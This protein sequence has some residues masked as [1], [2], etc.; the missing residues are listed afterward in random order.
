MKKRIL[1]VFL[2][3]C[4]VLTLF[5]M[6]AF[7]VSFDDTQGHW[8]KASIDRWAGYGVL[9]GDKGHFNPNG[10]MTRAQFAQ[11][12][13]NMLG[14]TEKA[15]NTFPDVKGDAWYAEAILKL[16]AAGVILGDN[17]GNANP[18]KPITR[19]EAAVMLCRAFHIDTSA[20]Q[21]IPFAD[22]GKVQSWARG[23]VAALA[24]K[25][26][27]NGVG[28][29]NF[30]PQNNINRAAVAQMADNMIS[31]YVTG[32]ETVT[33]KVDGLVVVAGNANVTFQN[34]EVAENI[35]VAPKGK[36]ATVALSG[37]TKASDVVL[38]GE[39]SKVTVGQTAS[40]DTV[41][42]AAPRTAAEVAGKANTVSTEKEAQ[43]AEVTV[44]QKGTVANVEVAGANNKVSVSGTVKKVDVES[45]G[46]NASVTTAEGAKVEAVTTN[47]SKTTV[48]GASN[49]VGTVT[50]GS[51]ATGAKVTTGGAKV[52]NKSPDKVVTGDGKEIAA[53]KTD[54]AV[55]DT[56]GGGSSSGGGG[57]GTVTPSYKYTV[58]ATV[59]DGKGGTVTASKTQTNE[60]EEITLTITPEK[61]WKIESVQ[62][63]APG[64]TDATPITDN[65]GYKFSINEAKE[66][67][68]TVEVT[69]VQPLTTFDAAIATSQEE[70]HAFFHKHFQVT[71]EQID[72][73][74]GDPAG[75]PWLLIAAKPSKDEYKISSSNLSFTINGQVATASWQGN[76]KSGTFTGCSLFVNS[77][78]Q[79]NTDVLACGDRKTGDIVATATVGGVTYTSAPVTFYV[80]GTTADSIIEMKFDANYTGAP[81]ATV[82]KTT[83]NQEEVAP[84]LKRAGYDLEG[85]YEEKGCTTKVTDFKVTDATIK[86]VTYYAKWTATE[87]SLTYNANGGTGSVERGE[88]TVEDTGLTAAA[89]TGLTKAGHTFKGWAFDKNATT[90]DY[91][92]GAAMRA[93]DLIAKANEKT[94]TLYAVWEA[95]TY[96]VT[97]QD[98]DK[99]I[100]EATA[101]YNE[102]VTL[103]EEIPSAEGKGFVGWYVA[104]TLFTDET[105]ITADTTVIAKWTEGS[106]PATGG[107]SASVTGV[108]GKLG[109]TAATNEDRTLTITIPADVKEKY[110]KLTDAEKAALNHED[111]L[112]IRVNS[113]VPDN[114][115][116][117]CFFTGST[118]NGLT[119]RAKCEM[120]KEALNAKGID[121]TEEGGKIKT[122]G[123]WFG[124]A[125]VNN[126]SGDNFQLITPA[127]NWQVIYRW[128]AA[129]GTMSYTTFKVAF[130]HAPAEA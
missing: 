84:E 102:T 45:T 7:A 39:G 77:A 56:S 91:A 103:P 65:G 113:N 32:N 118:D 43:N 11:M 55:P 73:A 95:A 126:E 111:R 107:V 70:V 42:M 44:S 85:W 117:K 130:V 104:N 49:T 129:D 48:S 98:G 58:K 99:V 88:V 64:D 92:A 10:Q 35:L 87:Y 89:S 119:W 19:Q 54:T 81:A 14:Y 60:A 125:T 78:A 34:A 21:N 29:N 74:Y 17:N 24:A 67:E 124:F 41:S 50:A 5:P 83:V 108:A 105:Q 115:G 2:A 12:L 110:E 122:I 76:G 97:F 27:I 100:K 63:K 106:I 15:P 3:F 128:T 6:A 38:E 75:D 31:H 90:P 72:A 82:L 59:K 40:A 66:G 96:K 127:N 30:A 68:Y 116:N 79:A 69:F 1:S 36:N 112:Y 33:G 80:K 120:T 4:L 16:K 61:G 121:V 25:G 26:M 23:A 93:E 62:Y 47:A 53:G 9:N 22:A 52:E 18:N 20:Y 114:I 101:K 13:A 57:G 109:I 51:G 86:S 8:G 28:G 94:I 71:D 123:Q 37:T 46:S